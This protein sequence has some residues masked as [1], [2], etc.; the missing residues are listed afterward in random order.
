SS[1]FL[2][3]EALLRR[4]IAHGSAER[5][6]IAMVAEQNRRMVGLLCFLRWGDTLAFYQSGWSPELASVEI[7][8]L[9][10]NES[11]KDAGADGMRTL[12][13]LRGNGP[14]A[15]DVR[16]RARIEAVSL[17]VDQRVLSDGGKRVDPI[18]KR[19]LGERLDGRRGLLLELR[20][21]QAQDPVD[22]NSTAV[23]PRAILG[24]SV[25]GVAV[26]E[27]GPRGARGSDVRLHRIQCVRFPRPLEAPRMPHKHRHVFAHVAPGAG[28]PPPAIVTED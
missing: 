19:A 25:Q 26:D 27:R 24:R 9:L 3:T 8:K 21:R 2:S 13:L 12:D 17:A 5:G 15:D 10:F 18:G 4:L 20:G 22:H 23:H 28:A 11:I 14:I 16:D 7:G 6:P 1:R